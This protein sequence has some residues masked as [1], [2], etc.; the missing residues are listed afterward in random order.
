NDAQ[1][2]EPKRDGSFSPGQIAAGLEVLPER[3]PRQPRAF[4][5]VTPLRPTG[6]F[7]WREADAEGVVKHRD[8]LLRLPGCLTHPG[9]SSSVV[10]ASVVEDTAS[11]ALTHEPDPA[12]D[13][14]L[15]VPNRGRLNQLERDYARQARPSPGAYQAYRRVA[16]AAPAR[17]ERIESVFGD[18]II[19]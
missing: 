4:P 12:G 8:A 17:P 18:M 7:I 14:V 2:P 19:C 1:S 10:C 3:R 16:S 5:S 6:H 9:P 13:C 11:P 15:R